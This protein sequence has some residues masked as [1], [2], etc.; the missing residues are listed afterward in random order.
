[1][2]SKREKFY[3][4]CRKLWAA[5]TAAVAATAI[6]ISGNHFTGAAYGAQWGNDQNVVIAPSATETVADSQ[7][8][9]SLVVNGSLS[10]NGNGNVNVSE[11]IVIGTAN[12]GSSVGSISVNGSGAKLTV[13]ASTNDPSDLT[14]VPGSSLTVQNNGQLELESGTSFENAARI[15]VNGNIVLSGSGLSESVVIGNY[16]LLNGSRLQAAYTP[17]NFYGLNANPGAVFGAGR[18]E[19]SGITVEMG[20]YAGIL[21]GTGGMSISNAAITRTENSGRQ[22]FES[23]G[24]LM[25]ITNS[26][27]DLGF[28]SYFK[29]GG[30]MQISNTEY[31]S[32][33]GFFISKDDMLISNGSKL[34]NSDGGGLTSTEGSVFISGNGTLVD[35][36][37]IGKVKAGS[38]ITI[39]EGAILKQGINSE[40]QANGDIR[41][42]NATVSQLSGGDISSNSGSI[43]ISGG[44]LSQGEQG[45]IYISNNSVGAAMIVIE[46]GANVKQGV[47]SSLLTHNS[48]GVGRGSIT[49]RGAA[50]RFEQGDFGQIESYGDLLF[51]S[52]ASVFQGKESSASTDGSARILGGSSLEQGNKSL[53][54]ASN[55]LEIQG[56]HIVQGDEGTIQAGNGGIAISQN[57]ASIR[58]GDDSVLTTTGSF[59]LTG[60]SRVE[61]GDDS[62]LTAGGSILLSSGAQILQEVSGSINAGQNIQLSGGSGISQFSGAGG[63]TPSQIIAAG[64]ISLTGGSSIDQGDYGFLQGQTIS[65][66]NS[67]ISQYYSGRILTGGS[68]ELKNDSEIYQENFGLIQTGENLLIENSVVQQGGNS[69]IDSGG[70]LTINS[71]EVS[72]WDQS[73]II[74]KG[75]ITIS[76]SE[77]IQGREGSITST[78]GNITI[79]ANSSVFQAV[80][81]GINNPSI[82]QAGIGKDITIHGEVR[83][84]ADGHIVTSGGGRLILDGAEIHQGERGWLY[85]SSDSDLVISDA[86]IYQGTSSD[87]QTQGNLIVDNSL[88]SQGENST[89]EALGDGNVVFRND[90]Q[91]TVGHNG[92]ITTRDTITIDDSRLIMDSGSMILNYSLDD[93]VRRDGSTNI[94]LSNGGQFLSESFRFTSDSIVLGDVDTRVSAT[95]GTLVLN[96]G[97]MLSGLGTVRTTEG[98]IVRDGSILRPGL[99]GDM[100]NDQIGST[101]TVVGGL[102]ITD[103]GILEIRVNDFGDHDKVVVRD[104]PSRPG[105]E[106][107]KVTIGDATLSLKTTQA[108]FLSGNTEIAFLWAESGIY[109]GEFKS[110]VEGNKFLAARQKITEFDDGSMEMSIS[111]ERTDYFTQYARDNGLGYNQTQVSRML[112]STDISGQWWDILSVLGEVSENYPRYYPLALNML[113]GEVKANSMTMYRETPW[114]SAMDQI[115]WVQNG[116]VFV[117]AQNRFSPNFCKQSEV[118]ATPFHTESR[119]S[120]DGNASRYEISTTGFMAGVNRRINNTTAAGVFFGY[121]RPELEQFLS[122]VEMDDFFVGLQ[123]GTML[124]SKVEMKALVV[125]G[126]QQYDMERMLYTG[127]IPN[128]PQTT[129]ISSDYD[130][131][132]LLASVEFARPFYFNN[133]AVLRPVLAFESEN[134]W[135]DGVREDG[136]SPFALQYKKRRD[137]RTF[138]RTGFTGELGAKRLKLNGKVFYSH[139]LGGQGYS[140]TDVRFAGVGNEFYDMRGIDLERHYLTVGAGGSFFLDPMKSR[141]VSAN[142]EA[143]ISEELTQ[144]MILISFSQLF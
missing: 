126:F 120:S 71:S 34:T 101:L 104:D 96:G 116:C 18:V 129:R 87:I 84:E 22:V 16:G 118:W 138:V 61:Q 45:L 14:V 81:N 112:D 57:G 83:Q 50:T 49:I 88:I 47:N 76:D 94:L 3:K 100:D 27:I 110:D 29:S 144:Q 7:E 117:G 137:D 58:Q 142:Y 140:H 115:G 8:A 35:Q 63:T 90:S 123:F 36:G 77:I 134:V 64:A 139:Q 113:S 20:D 53:L 114:R 131:N 111:L 51:E 23:A 130:G 68:L 11:N 62:E 52:G 107:G 13:G 42:T 37:Y 79:D 40:I 127:I 109:G 60:E 141:I 28:D 54:G 24:G 98:L 1:M 19:I 121:S 119:Y 99:G 124:T 67:E 80:G 105:V 132:T 73:D 6:F 136:N 135:Q 31:N 65:L 4:L 15:G 10:I 70:T 95:A 9:Q 59:S 122:S 43:A 93:P 32:V 72:Q 2:S 89:I 97:T 106:N 17:G 103:G 128:Q 33:R 82:I 133:C 46:N 30:G 55:A 5:S 92:W 39:S 108:D 44:S 21:G 78:E 125:G 86:T 74:A 85:N 26:T 91:I 48:D 41:F 38:Q 56:G 25:S 75:D 12:Q 69:T 66:D 143:T 102:I